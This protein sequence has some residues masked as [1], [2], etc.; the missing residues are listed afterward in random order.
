MKRVLVAYASKHNATAEIAIAI[1]ETL[2]QAGGLE[3]TVEAITPAV[4]LIE[5]DA[6]VVGSAVYMGQWQPEAANFLRQHERELTQRPV[7]VFSSGPVGKSDPKTLMDGWIFPETLQPL[8]KR[9]QPRDI[10]LFH[11][12]IDETWL[13]IFDRISVKFFDAQESDTRDW[14]MIRAWAQQI[15]D[16][17]KAD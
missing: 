16:A 13:K 17:L 14:Q 11:G 8:I 3:V 12:R 7:W 4:D 1:G 10:V 2:R 6:V 15:A 5:I 9:I